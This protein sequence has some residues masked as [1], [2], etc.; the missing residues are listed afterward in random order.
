MRHGNSLHK[1]ICLDV[2]PTM[3]HFMRMKRQLNRLEMTLWREQVGGPDEAAMLIKAALDCSLSK[4]EKLATG[5]YP[6]LPTAS[7]Q[8][9]LASLMNRP[10]DTLF[11]QIDKAKRTRAS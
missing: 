5:R 10:R 2:M 4:A 7:E 11:P 9:A 8:S 6:S 3:R 1:G